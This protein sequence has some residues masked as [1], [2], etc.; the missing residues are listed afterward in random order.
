MFIKHVQFL[1]TTEMLSPLFVILCITKM[2][3]SDLA[4]AQ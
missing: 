2:L 4:I 1:L 3:F